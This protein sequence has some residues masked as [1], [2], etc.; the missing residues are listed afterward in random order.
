[1]NSMNFV[2]QEDDP[3]RLDIYLVEQFKESSEYHL[4]RSQLKKHIENGAV[5]I[6]KKKIHKAGYQIEAQDEIVFTLLAPEGEPLE[7]YD[8]PLNIIHEEENFIVINKPAGLTVH[9]GAGTG[10][11]TL[12]NALIHHKHISPQQF[13]SQG[14]TASDRPGIVHRLDKE[15]TGVMVIA[16]NLST[17]ANLSEQFQKR[18]VKKEYLALV[19]RKLRGGLPFD[20]D[21]EGIIEAPI[22]RSSFKRTQMSVRED[23]RE[24][25]TEW[26]IKNRYKYAY[27]LEIQLLTGRT[28]QIRVHMDHVGSGVIGD[29]VYGNFETFPKDVLKA[30]KTFGRQALHSE[31]ITFLHPITEKPCTFK[32]PIPSDLSSLISYFSEE[33]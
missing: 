28:H 12:L 24:S 3:K 13:I 32:A 29:P 33:S 22:G 23:G 26:K 8:F 4:T 21:D 17:L 16:K 11:K 30:A 9:P 6:N 1:M 2:V 5:T 20:K 15:T 18:V 10:N 14:A 19:L 7:P 25:K 31:S 27:L